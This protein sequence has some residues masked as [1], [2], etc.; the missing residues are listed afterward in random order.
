MYIHTNKRVCASEYW[1]TVFILYYIILYYIILYYIIL[2]YIIYIYHKSV[3]VFVNG[4]H[5]MFSIYI[6]THMEVRMHR[7]MHRCTA[8]WIDFWIS[9][10][11]DNSSALP[12]LLMPFSLSFSAFTIF[13]LFFTCFSLVFH[14]LSQSFLFPL[15]E[16][17][18][19]EFVRG[20][21]RTASLWWLAPRLIVTVCHSLSLFHSIIF[22]ITRSIRRTRG[23][24]GIFVTLSQ[25]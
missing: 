10:R 14:N 5:N 13:H 19:V 15:W 2:C 9:P 23:I 18:S 25:A 24:K 4:M 22:K 17:I 11:T 20:Q 16:E 21:R 6:H 12:A 8:L 1:Y 3:R 7:Q